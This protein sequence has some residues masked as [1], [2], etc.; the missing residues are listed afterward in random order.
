MK[1]LLLYALLVLFSQSVHGQSL[2]QNIEGR[3]TTT[4]NGMW[5]TIVDPYENGYYD[6][7]YEPKTDGYFKNQKPATKSDLIEYDFDKSAQL[8]VPGDW[9]SQ[10]ESLFQIGRAHV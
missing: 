3:R 9:N 8:S 10:R 4:L 1:S 7:R 5:Q 6:Y 2:I